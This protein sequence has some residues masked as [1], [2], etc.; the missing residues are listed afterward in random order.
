MQCILNVIAHKRLP[1]LGL[2]GVHLL[3][4]VTTM[5]SL[6]PFSL[7]LF[8]PLDAT[9]FVNLVLGLPRRTLYM[10]CLLLLLV[11]GR[12]LIGFKQL[13]V[14]L[15]FA[16]TAITI[17]YFTVDLLEKFL[18]IIPEAPLDPEQLVELVLPT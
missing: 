8:F 15:L 12:L 5:L 11:G 4:Q 17:I 13:L 3:Y 2:L 9:L 7:D 16:A 18:L 10:N 6:L 1:F 14:E